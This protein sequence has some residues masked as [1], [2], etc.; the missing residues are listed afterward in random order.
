MK[1]PLTRLGW[2]EF[3]VRLYNKTGRD[4]ALH[5][6]MWYYLLHLAFDGN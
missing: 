2:H 4:S 6:A 3:Y 5:L 1:M